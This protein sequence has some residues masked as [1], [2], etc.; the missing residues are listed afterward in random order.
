LGNIS[1]GLPLSREEWPQEV[2]QAAAQFGCGDVVQNPPYFYF[3]D[4]AYAVLD[5]TKRYKDGSQG[6][7]LIDASGL[8]A[9]FG[10]VTSQTC[11]VGEIAFPFP[12]KPFI[13]VSP[14]FDGSGLDG[15]LRK[16]LRKGTAVQA[17]L[18]L[19]ALSE[20][21]EG[22]WVADFRLEMP[23]EKSWLVGRVPIRGFATEEEARMVPKVIGQLRSRP[24]WADSV[25]DSVG[26]T[27]LKAL[28]E[29]KSGNRGLFDSVTSG[30]DEIGVKADSMLNPRWI[31][32]MAFSHEV[33][34]DGVH[35]WWESTTDR[36]R[37]AA[38]GQGLKVQATGTAS[39]DTIP[40]SHY[41]LYVTANL[42][43][44]SPQ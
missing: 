21:H 39:L 41:R 9:P 31:E 35:E 28:G 29:L 18:H 32:V 23:I 8:A 13:Q 7:E 12:S 5:R 26:S 27:L 25:N 40:V 15:S 36:I 1:D 4:P 38:N 16:L 43:R 20:Q 14:V 6:P 33:L 44:H 30:I 2:L 10:I 19:P 3:A 24:A 17:F 11:D 37:E 22:F 42:S 34:E